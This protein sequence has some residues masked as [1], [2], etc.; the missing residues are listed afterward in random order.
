MHR[1][2]TRRI[3]V[4]LIKSNDMSANKYFDFTSLIL[5]VANDGLSIKAA[6]KRA[7]TCKKCSPRRE[8]MPGLSEYK[9]A[10]QSY[11]QHEAII[12]KVAG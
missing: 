4:L 11:P 6:A 7:A 10:L 12:D 3:F 9:Y 8:V 5:A 1:I 2:D